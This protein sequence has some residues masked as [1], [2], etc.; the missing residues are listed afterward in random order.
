M[1]T[2]SFR[3]LNQKGRWCY[4]G[5]DEAS[6]SDFFAGFDPSRVNGDELLRAETRGQFTGLKDK[7]GKKIF[8]GDI[9][10]RPLHLNE[11]C[12]VG[13]IGGGFIAHYICGDARLDDY[14]S[15]G[16][17][18]WEVIGNIHANPDLLN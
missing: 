11:V 15:L 1:Q 8:E 5:P 4:G 13:F 10:R 7:N 2:I 16:R 9:V 12:P 3:A 6:I 17:G 18:E 14:V